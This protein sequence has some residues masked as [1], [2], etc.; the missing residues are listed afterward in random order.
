[1]TDAIIREDELQ[2][3]INSL[4]EV[5]ITYPLYPGDIL[6]ARPEGIGFR[7]QL[8]ASRETFQNWLSGYGPIAGESRRITISR[9][10][11]LQA[12]SPVM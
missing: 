8:P 10:A 5:H 4:D 12:G 1:M 3:L 11:C 2:I 7:I 9:N 6:I